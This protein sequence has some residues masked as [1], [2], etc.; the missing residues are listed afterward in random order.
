MKIVELTGTKVLK[1]PGREQL[2]NICLF[3]LSLLTSLQCWGRR[4]RPGK[5]D[6]LIEP[7]Q[8]KGDK[9]E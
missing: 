3:N 6:R 7:F 9:W 4:A 8:V 1:F 5:E 2:I